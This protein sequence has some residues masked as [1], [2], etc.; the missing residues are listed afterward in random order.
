ME[1]NDIE[2]Y[3][4]IVVKS[5]LKEAREDLREV[6]GFHIK[7]EQAIAVELVKARTA[8]FNNVLAQGMSAIETANKEHFD[9]VFNASPHESG[10]EV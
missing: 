4:R 6:F 7:E 2:K 3:S 5:F 8:L 9:K 10:E 1:L